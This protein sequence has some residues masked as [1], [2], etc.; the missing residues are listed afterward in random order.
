MVTSPCND[1]ESGEQSSLED[2]KKQE[3]VSAAKCED[4]KGLKGGEGDN[5]GTLM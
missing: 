3:E 5:I 4:E 1:Q 2:H